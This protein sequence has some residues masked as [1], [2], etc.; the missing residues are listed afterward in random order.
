MRMSLLLI[1]FTLALSACGVKRPLM[2][3]E[4]VPAYEE[5]R[6]KEMQERLREREEDQKRQQLLQPIQPR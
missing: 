1:A 3:P 5:K 6:T 4:D 2:K